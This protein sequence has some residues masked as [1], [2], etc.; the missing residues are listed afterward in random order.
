MVD[1]HTVQLMYQAIQLALKH[2]VAL[3]HQARSQTSMELQQE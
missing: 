3:Y 1:G 2:A